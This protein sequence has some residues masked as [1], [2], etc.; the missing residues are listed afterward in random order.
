M[1]ANR[2]FPAI[3]IGA[4][5]VTVSTTASTSANGTIPTT[6]TGA[7]PRYVRVASNGTVYVRLTVGAGTAVTSDVM[8][9]S[10]SPLI[11]ETLGYTHYAVIDDGTTVKVNIAPMEDN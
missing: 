11:L 8:V 5:G 3:N 9:T 6:S 7:K 10:G 2:Q 4:T 1:G